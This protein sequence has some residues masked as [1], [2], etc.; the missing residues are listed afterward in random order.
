M[1][2]RLEA[3]LNKTLFSENSFAPRN[4]GLINN[5]AA[6]EIVKEPVHPVLKGY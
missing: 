1:D 3:G 4:V 5:R 6:I 2:W